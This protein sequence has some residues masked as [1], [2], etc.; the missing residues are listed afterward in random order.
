MSKDNTITIKNNWDEITW[1][2]FFEIRQILLCDIPEE[3][4]TINLVALLTGEPIQT[5]ENLPISVF[6]K[7]SSHLD[8][9]NDI[10]TDTPMHKDVYEVD[11]RRYILR[12]NVPSITT[13]QYMD[14]CN[15]S[16]EKPEPD[17]R[18]LVACFLVPENH[19]Y[20]DGYDIQTVWN[21]VGKMNFRD[22]QSVAFFLRKQYGL[23]TITTIDYLIREAGEMRRKKQITKEKEKELKDQFHQLQNMVYSLTFS[24]SLK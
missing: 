6:K 8:F 21:D 17:T 23:F 3:Y 4:K 5:I 24:E 19:S 22:V 7:L 15:F 2:E 18:K 14:Y 20:N 13:A 9:L 1:D 12:A 10:P 16:K 11:G